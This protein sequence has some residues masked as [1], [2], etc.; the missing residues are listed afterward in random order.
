[1][2]TAILHNKAGRIQIQGEETRVRWREVFQRS[3]DLLSSVFFSR[4]RYLS[5]Q[6]M[7]RVMALL[8]GYEAATALGEL[9]RIQFW[10]R[11]EGTNGRF[12]VEPDV[13]MHFTNALVVIEVKPPFGGMQYIEQWHAQIQALA[14]NLAEKDAAPQ[15]VHFVGLGNNTMD[16]N[17]QALAELDVQDAFTLVL[18]QAEW[19]AI[20]HALPSLHTD[21]IASDRA[22]FDDWRDAFGL[23]GMALHPIFE[24]P[25]LLTWA[26]RC[27]LSTAEVPWPIWST[28]LPV[29]PVHA[30]VPASASSENLPTGSI[31]WSD[32]LSFSVTHPLHQP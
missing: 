12:W 30:S 23:F 2:L 10:P 24:W 7:T 15:R 6:S 27:G 11:L 17:A 19:S 29:A 16:L 5:P 31:D 14:Q 22:V 9:Q 20:T 4:L 32:L 3:E 18:H 13:Q 25:E 26:A 28:Q 8:M 1:M 21:A